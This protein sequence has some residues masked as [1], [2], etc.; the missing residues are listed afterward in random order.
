MNESCFLLLTGTPPP[1]ANMNS[2]KNDK[3]DYK[4]KGIKGNM[5]ARIKHAKKKEELSVTGTLQNKTKK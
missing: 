4:Q 5:T 2:I 1:N 3:I